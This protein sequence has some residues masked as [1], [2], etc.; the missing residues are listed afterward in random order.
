MSEMNS[1]DKALSFIVATIT[2][3]VCFIFAQIR[4]C[5][6]ARLKIEQEQLKEQSK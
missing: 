3:G 6:E 1:D 4:A 5:E 2:I